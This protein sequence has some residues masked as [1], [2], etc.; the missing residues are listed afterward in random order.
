MTNMLN[1]TQI[2]ITINPQNAKERGL[3]YTGDFVYDVRNQNGLS[4]TLIYCFNN[5]S[6]AGSPA[7]P[8]TLGWAHGKKFGLYTPQDLPTPTINIDWSINQNTAKDHGLKWVEDIMFD[9]GVP[10]SENIDILLRYWDSTYI[11]G[12][13]LSNEEFMVGIYE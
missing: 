2:D 3:A 1:K 9:Q 7:S 5:K 12:K 8:S 6:I 11:W 13:P 4:K 10:L